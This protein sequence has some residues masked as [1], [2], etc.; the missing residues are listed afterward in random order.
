MMTTSKKAILTAITA[1]PL[2]ALGGGLAYAN[3]GGGT[4]PA[5]AVTTATTTSTA[6]PAAPA[7]GTGQHPA[8]GTC[9]TGTWHYSD[10]RWCCDTHAGSQ[11]PAARHQP[12]QG[13]ATQVRATQNQA[14]Q[15]QAT[16][17]SGY[18]HGSGYQ[19]NGQHGYYQQAGHQGHDDG[20]RDR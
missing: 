9:R 8:A 20:C 1:A 13:R 3:T 7:P 5:P 11:A 12:S 16:R 17:G 19:G 10:G 2:L 4:P 15:G 18:Q 6:T 14:G